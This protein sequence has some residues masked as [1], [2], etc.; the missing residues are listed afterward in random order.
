MSSLDFLNLTE[1]SEQIR[2]RCISPVE[3]TRLCLDRINEYDGGLSS[4]LTVTGDRALKQ[5]SLAEEEISNGRLLGPLHGIPIALKDLI[6]TK[7]I[8]TTGGMSLY[9]DRVPLFDATVVER[10]DRAGAVILRKLKT[11]EG[12]LFNH[13]LPWFRRATR[14]TAIIGREYQRP[15]GFGKVR[16]VA[17]PER[18]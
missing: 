15:G 9:K 5:A 3:V 13:H 12:A 7:G 14:G 4:Y 6:S 10:L 16:N 8:V 17:C 11:T 1:L 2:P 18:P